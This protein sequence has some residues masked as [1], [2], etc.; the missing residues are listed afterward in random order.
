M[1]YKNQQNMIKITK[2][3]IYLL[4]KKNKKPKKFNDS[5][6]EIYFSYKIAIFFRI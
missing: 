5:Y 4:K 6:N 1:I 2:I 3:M